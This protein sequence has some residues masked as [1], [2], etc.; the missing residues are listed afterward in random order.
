MVMSWDGLSAGV[1]TADWQLFVHIKVVMSIDYKIY[2][3]C[4][5]SWDVPSAGISTANW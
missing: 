1:P 3:V 4:E 5:M 2:N